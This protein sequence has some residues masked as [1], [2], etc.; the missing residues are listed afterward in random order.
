MDTKE[1]DIS[2]TIQN[3][4]VFGI[5][6]GIFPFAP[7]KLTTVSFL[8]GLVMLAYRWFK[9]HQKPDCWGKIQWPPIL[10]MLFFVA[11]LILASQ[12][13]LDVH[14]SSNVAYNYFKYMKPALM[15]IVLMNSKAGFVQAVAYSFLCVTMYMCLGP[16][17]LIKEYFWQRLSTNH[18]I[19]IFDHRNILS[20][21]LALQVP[22][23]IWWFFRLNRSFINKF[24]WMLALIIVLL[25][26]VSAQSRGAFMALFFTAIV[27]LVAM[28][29]SKDFNKTKVIV[30]A[31]T[32]GV[33]IFGSFQFLPKDNHLWQLEETME[34]GKRPITQYNDKG[35]LYLYEGA[36]KMIKDRPIFGVGL[37]NFNK[38]YV[39][40]YM[41]KGAIEKRL[42]HAHNVILA[43][44]T[45]SGVVGLI[46]FLVS[47]ITYVYFF[48]KNRYHHGIIYM[49]LAGMLVFFLQNL[50]DFFFYHYLIEMVY[51]LILA[52]GYTWICVNVPEKRQA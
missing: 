50:V 41:V 1:I 2:Y 6:L 39:S 34:Y 52:T 33:V 38:V 40:H 15:I 3:L 44:L 16:V 28:A 51:W 49:V 35:R 11:M 45:T 18:P 17:N 43:F 25:T 47:Q 8:V 27:F 31:L 7:E 36:M 20:S 5:V 9:Y 32:L 26:L 13:S 37:D 23:Y 22:F 4:A 12:F 10:G 30:A 29:F 24:I 21:Y 19:A 48:M 14:K 46:G 42:Y